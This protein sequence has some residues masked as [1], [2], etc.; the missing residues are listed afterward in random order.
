[1]GLGINRAF[2]DVVYRI[3]FSA[4]IPMTWRWKVLNRLG[5]KGIS[6]SNIRD[7]CLIIGFDITMSDCYFNRQVFVDASA[8]VRIGTRVQF[9][10]RASIITSTHRI[11][12]SAQRAIGAETAPVSVG[13][14][15]WIG[16]GAM[17]LPGVSVA[18]GCV[19]AAGAV[20]TKD[21]AQDGLYAGVPAT[22]VRDLEPR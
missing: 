21:T 22:R 5:W 18:R 14:G 4:A 2:H 17:I 3:A 10:P 7:G 1:M 11:G 20:V 15:C 19:I 6:R 13:D 16:A 8:P 9:G 12:T